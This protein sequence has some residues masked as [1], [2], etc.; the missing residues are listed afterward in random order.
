MA[1]ESTFRLNR[2]TV[3]ITSEFFGPSML[4]HDLL[5]ASG[6]VPQEWELGDN[7][8]HLGPTGVGVDF[9]NGVEW[10]MTPARLDIGRAC[11]GR[12]EEDY[13][14][15]DLAKAYLRTF[16]FVPYRNLG[17]NWSM[18]TRLR[19]PER[20][21][22]RRFLKAGPWLKDGPEIIRMRPSFSLDAGDAVCNL[23]FKSVRL[24]LNDGEYEDRVTV[25]C[26]IHYPA[27]LDTERRIAAIARWQDH[28]QFILAALAQL[29]ERRDT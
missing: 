16:P 9:R 11:N 23:D 21:L 2:V 6:I 20:W 15:H 29:A 3:V 1:F 28:E 13:L 14:V 5:L 10:N 17:L 19:E 25:D 18:Y 24:E 26:N 27:D 7:G 4:S 12:F 22:T 8:E